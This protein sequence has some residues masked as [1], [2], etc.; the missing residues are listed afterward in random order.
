MWNNVLIGG[1]QLQACYVS[2]TKCLEKYPNLNSCTEIAAYFILL[3][4][5]LSCLLP[6][7]FIYI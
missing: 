4:F 5:T 6:A 1:I 3:R 2:F 7:L